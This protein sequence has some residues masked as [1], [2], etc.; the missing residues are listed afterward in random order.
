MKAWLPNRR[1]VDAAA[2]LSELN[3]NELADVSTLCGVPTKFQPATK[4]VCTGFR[5]ISSPARVNWTGV[6][7]NTQ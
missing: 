3:E 2:R 6:L 4:L 1:F 5:A 7:Q